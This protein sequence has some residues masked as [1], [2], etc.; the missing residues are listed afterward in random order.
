MT[1]KEFYNS[2]YWEAL[3][4][5]SFYLTEW[6]YYTE[7]EK[8]EDKAKELIGG[9]LKKYEYKEACK[10]W[11]DSLSNNDKE[12]IQSIPNF[13]KDVFKDITGITN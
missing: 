7:K 3:N 13:D 12:T 10:R 1:H 11:W 4:S 5:G 2:K 9:Y 8:A 6:V